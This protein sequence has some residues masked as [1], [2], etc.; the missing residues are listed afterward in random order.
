M[1][2]GELAARFAHPE[3]IA[4]WDSLISRNPAGGD[5]LMSA[6]FADAKASVG[7]NPRHLVFEDG[8]A[9][10]S[11][12]L[13]LERRIPLLGRYWY[14]AKGPGAVTVGELKA[15]ISALRQ[16]IA[17]S[18]SRV[19]AVTLEPP[20]LATEDTET[21]LEES[22][23]LAELGVLRRPGIQGNVHT[24]IVNIDRTDE[25]LLASFDSKC[26][27]MV[28]RA[29]RDGV[30]VRRFAATQH[31][32]DEMFR[33]MHLVGGGKAKLA[34]RSQAYLEKMWRTFDA[35]NEGYFFGIEVDGTPAVLS[36]MVVIGDRAFYKDGG[37][38]RPRTS[39]GMSNLV[40]FEMMR[41]ARD[42]GAR[43]YD[44]FGIAPE[45]AS[46][47]DDHPAWALGMF[48]LSFA[49][50]RTDYIGGFDLVLR[51]KQYALWQRIGKRLTS[52][53]H[54][55]RFNDLDLY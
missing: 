53:W 8:G 23:S 55:R 50:T 33:L 14:L 19:F 13:V 17:S 21:Q 11:A 6:G 5:F 18:R 3:E 54:R 51:N 26:R 35:N 2:Q 29:Q 9:F 32:F 31:T 4:S 16:L 48:K 28:R 43:S 10:V 42:A 34:L 27:N 15:H 40:Q 7:W 12:A 1:R 44:M 38:E 36:Y 49:R 41:A 24:A 52:A 47:N 45:S 22:P 20:V 25:E 39:P 30:T 46:S 37:S